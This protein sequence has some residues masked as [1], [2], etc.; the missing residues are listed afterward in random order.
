MPNDTPMLAGDFLAYG[1]NSE[2]GNG[3][4]DI[5]LP[6]GDF[7]TVASGTTLTIT[8]TDGTM[9]ADNTG[10]TPV[11]TINWNAGGSEIQTIG[12]VGNQVVEDDQGFAGSNGTGTQLYDQQIV[13]SLDTNLVTDT[14]S[15]QGAVTALNGATVTLDDGASAKL[16]GYPKPGGSDSASG[17]G[18]TVIVGSNDSLTIKGGTSNTVA[19]SGDNSA[20]SDDSASSGNSFTLNGSGDTITLS[21]SGD[22]VVISGTGDTITVGGSSDTLNITGSGTTVI[23]ASGAALTTDTL[24]FHGQS[25]AGGY[26]IG[27]TDQFGRTY[28]LNGT[29]LTISTS[30]D[31]LTVNNFQNGDFGLYLGTHGYAYSDIPFP[32]SEGSINDGGEIVGNFNGDRLFIDNN[33]AISIIPVPGGVYSIGGISNNGMIALNG[34]G[35]S[36]YIYDNGTFTPVSISAG[37]GFPVLTDIND[38]GEIVGYAVQLNGGDGNVISGFLDNNGTMSSVQVPGSTQTFV[39]GINDKWVMVGFY[40]NGNSISGFVD[41]GGV[42]TTIVVPSSIYTHVNG[43]NNNGVIIGNYATADGRVH[44][45]TDNA[46]VFTTIDNPN[47]T[48]TNLTGINDSGEVVGKANTLFTAIPIPAVSISDTGTVYTLNNDNVDI[49]PGAQTT[50]NGANDFINVGNDSTTDIAATG[51]TLMTDTVSFNS[52]GEQITL[53]NGDVFTLRSVQAA[54]VA[55]DGTLIANNNANGDGVI[56]ST[57]NWNTGGSEVQTFT[58]ASD[59]SYTEDAK[60]Y[61]GSTGSGTFLYEQ[62]THVPTTGPVTATI[63]GTGDVT[64]LNNTTITL[65]DATSVSLS[66]NNNVIIVSGATDTVNISQSSTLAGDMESFNIRGSEL[67]SFNN[68]DEMVVSSGVSMTIIGSDGTMIVN[69]NANGD[70]VI[71]NIVDFIAGG[72]EVEKLSGLAAGVKEVDLNYSGADGT[73]TLL[74]KVVDLA[75]G[76]SKQV[77]LTSLPAG[78]GRETLF[79]SSANLTGTLTKAITD[80]TAG[81][82]SV[83][84]FNPSANVLGNTKNYS[85]LDGTGTLNSQ[86]LDLTDGTSKEIIYTGLP[87]GV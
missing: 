21:D 55:A 78:V 34:G 15:G 26:S 7:V 9:T 20:V 2:N 76:T 73:G 70:G 48:S 72:S 42:F 74:S 11:N 77:L 69:D 14:I 82:S 49:A 86:V 19:V 13:T 57:V 68:G 5:F 84:V 32:V 44:G 36:N 43:I 8:G 63:S 17:S 52:Y 87:T 50:I 40:Q 47:G 60:G 4:E 64:A 83:E 79:Y 1:P 27:D 81:N 65:A 10:P 56:A 61:S 46:G 33:G 59:D 45:F 28:S 85:G 51:S 80:F 41:N 16:V 75:S 35:A 62:I 58:V 31:T 18:N 6:C 25:I 54:I 39:T 37:P 53:S 30:T 22:S 24:N 71:Q 23:A 29:T 3:E 66:G 12:V 38:S 67:I